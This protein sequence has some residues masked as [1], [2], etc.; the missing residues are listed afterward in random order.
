MKKSIVF[1]V[2]F[3]LL[4]GMFTVPASAEKGVIKVEAEA[5]T[6]KV[7]T[8][9]WAESLGMRMYSGNYGEY[10]VEFAQAGAYDVQ[11]NAKIFETMNHS[12]KVYLDGLLQATTD[13]GSLTNAS[14]YALH[15]VGTIT[16]AEPGT[17]KIKIELTS[18]N[19]GFDYFVLTP[20]TDISFNISS[21]KH[22]KTGTIAID[23]DWDK[24]IYLSTNGWVE[25][26]IEFPSAGI[27]DLKLDCGTYQ[28]VYTSVTLDGIKQRQ[29]AS[30][31]SPIYESESKIYS[32]FTETDY[33]TV[34]VPTAGTHSLK[35]SMT[36]SGINLT[37][38]TLKFTRTGDCDI[39]VNVAGTAYNTAESAV[40]LTSADHVQLYSSGKY[41]TYD[42]NFLAKGVYNLS[43]M[44]DSAYGSK[45]DIY[46]GENLMFDDKTIGAES[47]GLT[48]IPR[49]LS[50]GQIYIDTPGT[51]KIKFAYTNSQFR[52]YNV[53]LTYCA[54]TPSVIITADY[55]SDTSKIGYKVSN[56]TS[57]AANAVI[58]CAVYENDD[59]TG[60]YTLKAVDKK[61]ITE[62]EAGKNTTAYTD[63]L[64]LASKDIVKVYVW[65][66]VNLYE[67]L[68]KSQYVMTA[69]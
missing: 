43:V 10:Y 7:D 16:V 58:Y 20:K 46:V 36:L 48:G 51:Y 1:L 19:I 55:D 24:Y 53:K 69:Q 31:I 63:T 44:H 59:S 18:G 12:T 64:S 14:S 34:V 25:Y 21:K 41:V 29:K 61:E 15:N 47:T 52:L 60:S 45:A 27:Y 50:L 40:S 56:Y 26:D 33:C 28:N 42:V 11:I 30:F 54:E 4:I 38:K 13:L 17:H 6:G 35:I 5:F 32:N 67:P 37:I 66:S 49:E 3:T 8:F 23:N 22:D 57:S 39:D 68:A 2:V 9:L 62:L 65:D